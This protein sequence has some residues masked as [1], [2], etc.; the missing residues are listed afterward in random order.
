MYKYLTYLLDFFNIILLFSAT[1]FVE[2]DSQKAVVAALDRSVTVELTVNGAKI[3]VDKF[4][5]R[6]TKSEKEKKKRSKKKRKT[7]K[8]K[9]DSENVTETPI[10]E[11][12][13]KDAPVEKALDNE[14]DS[15]DDSDSD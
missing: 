10:V 11:V 8:N 9:S 1:A 14:A 2:F 7:K 3:M 12:S 4:E 13:S 6:E 15:D 5:L